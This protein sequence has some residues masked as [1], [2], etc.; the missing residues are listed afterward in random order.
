MRVAIIV[1]VSPY[2]PAEILV[3]SVRHLKSLEFGKMR[4]KILYVLDLN[5]KNDNRGEILKKEGVEVLQRENTRG[6]RAGA[7]ND[8]LKA[9]KDF[10]PTYIAIFDVD[11][12]PAKD[13]IVKCVKALDAE[14]RAYIASSP[15]YISNATNLVSSTICAE[16]MLINFLLK[17]TGFKQFNGLIGVLRADYLFKYRLK[18]DAVAEDA[19][20]ATRMHAKRFKALLVNTAVYEQAPLTWRDLLN[21]R[22]RW[23]YGGLQLW[24]YWKDVKRSGRPKF[25]RGWVMALTLTYFVFLLSPLILLSPPL[26]LYKFKNVKKLPVI[27][28]LAIHAFLLQYAAFRAMVN[29]GKKKG[30]EWKAIKRS[31]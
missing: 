14:P 30:V 26:I 18:E 20:F 4:V 19:D 22:E 16:Y 23:Y 27:A 7:I 13:F 1:P 11:S 5:G 12:R 6:K 3:Q 21:Q 24:K 15:R 10:K 9:L 28:G 31:L 29:F 17:R 25:I 8:A 2:E